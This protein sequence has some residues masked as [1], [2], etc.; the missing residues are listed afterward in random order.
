MECEQL[1]E[2]SGRPI[3]T[4][5]LSHVSLWQKAVSSNPDK[6]ALISHDQSP[7]S[8]GWIRGAGPCRTHVEWTFADLDRASRR[9][10]T[11][12]NRLAPVGRRPI[13]TFVNNQAEWALFFWA[14]AYLHVP[15]MPINPKCAGRSEEV[16]HMLAL[17]KPG[18]VVAA[19]AD[20]ACQLELNVSSTILDDI[21]TKLLLCATD[22]IASSEWNQ[23]SHIM[24]GELTPADTPLLPDPDAHALILFTSGTTSLPKPCAHTSAQVANAALAYT[25]ARGITDAHRLVHHL[26]GFH[27]YGIT[28]GLVFWFSGGSIVYPSAAFEAQASL[29]CIQRYKCTH[30]SLVPTT[31]QAILAHSALANTDLSS[32]VSI[33]VSGAGVLPSLVKSCEEAL[34]I[35]AYTSYGMTES[36][37][38]IIWPDGGGSVLR[39]GDVLAGFPS[40]GV[41][42]KVCEP[43]TRVAVPRGHAGELHCTGIQVISGYLDAEVSSS[44]F[45]VDEDDRSWVVSGDQ[46][47]MTED[48]ALCIV[49]RYKDL[50]IR[51]GE[52][53][54]PA[55]I[56]DL[57]CKVEGVQM[58]QVVGVPDDMAG[59]VPIAIIQVL[60]GYHIAASELKRLTTQHLGPAFA[61]KLV[62]N[63]QDDL[64]LE[65]YPMTASGKVRKVEL[66]QLV[67]KYLSERDGPNL[68]DDAPTVDIL[69][70]IWNEISGASGL[71]P[72]TNIQSFA[73]SLMMMQLSRM[74]KCALEKDITV[75]HF[76]KCDT[77]LDQANLIDQR[78]KR[79]TQVDRASRIGPPTIDDIAYLQGDSSTFQQ[80]R[81]SV[82]SALSIMNLSW[83]D[84][85]DVMPL[86]DWEAIFVNRSRPQSWNLRWTC[87]AP[88]DAR[89]L[90]AA[91]RSTMAVHPTLRSIAVLSNEDTPLLVSIRP[92]EQWMKN[93][94]TTGWSVSDKDELK[95]LLLG[96][97]VQDCASFP[98]PLFRVHIATIES[99]GTAG[100]VIVAS[101]AVMDASM[102]KLWLDDINA[103]L[104]GNGTPGPHALYK[105][106]AAAYHSHRF[107]SEAMK[108]VAYWAEKLQGVSSI[109]ES[110]YWPPQRAPEWF[111]GCDYG[112]THWDGSETSE[113]MRSRSQL[114]KNKAQNGIRRLA[115][116]QD[117]AHLKSDHNVP[118]FMLMKA[119][120]ALL[121][122]KQT[123]GREA[124]FG[125][126]N[127]AR[128]W[129]F[130]SDYSATEQEK[131]SGNP[132][133]ISG[134]TI[135]YLLDRVHVETQTMVLKFMQKVTAEEETNSA[136]AHAPFFDI[137]E[138]LRHSISA[139]DARTVEQRNSDAESLLPLIRRQS[140]NWLPTSPNA[141]RDPNGLAMLD[142]V[143]RMDNGLTI[144]G[145]LADD[146]RSVALDFR[147]DAEH[148]T[149]TE[150]EEA[151]D[152]LAK[153]IEEMG[154]EENWMRSLKDII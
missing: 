34:K 44:A 142:M 69:I 45:Y 78:P 38:T 114:E 128:T 126:I 37:G 74:V 68:H 108:G 72:G 151:I 80:T 32:L 111:K 139:N 101:H 59:E 81:R 16:S 1:S 119:A 84:V 149:M 136:H 77:I 154:K 6:V 140:F 36:P 43:G 58:A 88:V 130:S 102:T 153:L 57:L 5:N 107:G 79:K 7:S 90:E 24:T 129:P 82:S 121:N 19:S 60:Q 76:K 23:L 110:E 17:M 125:T 71:Q 18:V 62:L 106:Y 46:A 50:I 94:I 104:H 115:R 66:R 47:I 40:R 20:L 86:P 85:E 30:T 87:H 135:E 99:D 143:T 83:S 96:H 11:T 29:D 4:H 15:L 95:D 65:T 131:F 93:S 98:G 21:P 100:L 137:V 105:D 150:A 122:V 109:P 144:T 10:A 112:W 141:Q 120:I 26:P 75:E 118:V 49:G 39:D 61:P 124:M 89:K 42:A 116:V 56:E 8:F 51:G 133:D 13:A 73:D 67:R 152:T 64:G 33:D 91:V 27:A 113:S 2:A 127:A 22:G 9:L 70:A 148:L 48:G 31:A 55:S 63:L 54:S 14:A 132:L 138:R 52:N 92:S 123:G 41:T 146:K 53:I 28:W 103:A 3:D 147:W 35:P 25:E 134:C 12:L 117:I 97:P 145:F